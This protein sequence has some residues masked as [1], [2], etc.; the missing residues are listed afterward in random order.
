M[1]GVDI[2]VFL[3]ILLSAIALR[4]LVLREGS[5]GDVTSSPSSA[6]KELPGAR[7]YVYFPQIRQAISAS[8]REYL[9]RT[10][11]S[12]VARQA[13]RERRAVVRRF[14]R[15]LRDDFSRLDKLGRAIAALSPEV[16]RPQET[17]R[18]LLNARFQALYA[19]VWLRLSIGMLPLD[20]LEVLAGMVGRLATRIDE[21]MTEINALSAGQLAGKLNA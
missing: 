4:L 2:L 16:S 21:A 18:L 14:L 1:N 3:V 17:Q 19:L 15:G 6:F 12:R 10:A 8:D 11:S 13:L 5:H 9:L 7:H 20:Q